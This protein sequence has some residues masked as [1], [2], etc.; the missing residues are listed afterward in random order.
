M[1]CCNPNTVVN[2]E[3]YLGRNGNVVYQVQPG[4][5][6]GIISERTGVSYNELRAANP[7]VGEGF[8]AGI[9]LNAPR[10]QQAQISLSQSAGNAEPNF[11]QQLNISMGPKIPE[12]LKNHINAMDIG[13]QSVPGLEQ[14]FGLKYSR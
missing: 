1:Y 10:V 8:D 11:N 2:V 13:L 7:K 9:V 5:N 6:W 4:D 14:S 3:T 12:L